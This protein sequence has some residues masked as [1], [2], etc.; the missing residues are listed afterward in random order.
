VASRAS[1][2]G[3]EAGAIQV[4][5]YAEEE[6][7]GGRQTGCRGGVEEVTGMVAANPQCEREEVM[8]WQMPTRSP[9]R[10]RLRRPTIGLL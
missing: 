3:Q 7:S 9:A 6:G 10:S 5:F 2:T 1:P 4:P 8:G